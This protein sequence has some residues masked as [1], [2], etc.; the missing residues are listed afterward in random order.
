MNSLPEIKLLETVIIDVGFTDF[1]RVK[2]NNIPFDELNDRIENLVRENDMKM[3][4]DSEDVTKP[5]DENS[6]E[7]SV[8]EIKASAD[9]SASFDHIKDSNEYIRLT[10]ETPEGAKSITIKKIGVDEETYERMDIDSKIPPKYKAN[11]FGYTTNH[12]TVHVTFEHLEGRPMW[13]YQE[14]LK[15]LGDLETIG[16]C[17][18]YDFLTE[19]LKGHTVQVML[20]KPKKCKVIGNKTE[21]YLRYGKEKHVLD[22]TE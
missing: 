3:E 11:F 9:T 12:P 19:P 5:L 22:S 1:D 10:K 2:F 15:I 4:M 8:S 13:T 16:I 20:D 7:I 21:I 14:V 18:P 17:H 6:L